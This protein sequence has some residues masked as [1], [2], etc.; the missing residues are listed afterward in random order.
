LS[1]NVVVKEGPKTTY[2][3]VSCRRRGKPDPDIF[4]EGPK[5]IT[6]FELPSLLPTLVYD[7]LF[8]SFSVEVIY[9]G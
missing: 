1:K 5:D 4:V 7:A 6:L 2:V 3:E 8:Y 9:L